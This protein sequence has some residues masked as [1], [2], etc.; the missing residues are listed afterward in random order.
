V[1]NMNSLIVFDLS[2]SATFR[3]TVNSGSPIFIS[4]MTLNRLLTS[5]VVLKAAWHRIAVAE[6]GF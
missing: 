5:K 4:P 1:V 6:G 3:L 2:G